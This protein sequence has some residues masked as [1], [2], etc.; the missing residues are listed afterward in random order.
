M[1]S[2]ILVCLIRLITILLLILAGIFSMGNAA[3]AASQ[4][5]TVT[6]HNN[7]TS[8]SNISVIQSANTASALKTFSTMGF[9]NP[10]Y[11][12]EDWATQQNGGGAVY[13][14]QAIYQFNA[15][16][17]LYA[18]W[19]QDSH[20]VTFFSNLTS[21]DTSHL[22]QTNNASAALTSISALSYSNLNYTFEGWNTQRNG[23]GVA[24]LDQA[25]YSFSGD[26]TL[27]AQ[28]SQDP[29][30]VTFFSNL[31]SSDTTHVIQ[32]ANAPAALTSISALSYSNLNYTFEGWNTQRN[33][34]GVAYVDQAVYP[35]SADITLYGQWSPDQY[36]LSF[37][38]NTGTG[39]V[40][41]IGATYGSTATLPQGT[42]MSKPG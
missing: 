28:W 18:Q 11:Y 24:Y 34:R 35:F 8:A 39:S 4:I 23:S 21:T 25:V 22:I 19:I 26:I 2:R 7:A 3:K 12:F 37:S 31:T 9:S 1:T 6:F 41:S 10:N 13:Q 20:S 14:D 40:P 29:H 16:V 30:A 38:S 33:G 36:N 15:D 27:Y 5:F 42:S 17:E 32:T